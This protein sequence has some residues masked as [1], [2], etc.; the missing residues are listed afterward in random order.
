MNCQWIKVTA[1]HANLPAAFEWRR[2]AGRTWS[3]ISVLTKKRNQLRPGRTPWA[4]CPPADGM[5]VR[6]T[7]SR[8]GGVIQRDAWICPLTE[9]CFYVSTAHYQRLVASSWNLHLPERSPSTRPPPHFVTRCNVRLPPAR[10]D[11]CRLRGVF[12]ACASGSLV[13]EYICNVP[14]AIQ[15]S[16][17]ERIRK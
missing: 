10:V 16:V 7:K 8:P 5:R 6:R 1:L 14:S 17:S 3:R 12:F 2:L 11:V 13:T 15:H 9:C 4:C